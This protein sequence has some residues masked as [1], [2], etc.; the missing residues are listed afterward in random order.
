M[1]TR[2]GRTLEP[3]RGAATA[4]AR[5]Y[6][7]EGALAYAPVVMWLRSQSLR[8]RVS[9]MDRSRLYELA[10]LLPELLDQ[11]PRP[12]P[13]LPLPASEQRQR[14]FDAV[15]AAVL[16]SGRPLLLVGDDVHWWDRE[17]LELLHY[18]LR[19]RPEA[20]LL[21]VATCRREEVDDTHPLNE[22]VT[23]MQL[24]ER[25][26]DIALERFTQ[27]ETAT[28]AERLTGMRLAEPAARE[29]FGE[30]EGN[31]LFVVEV[32]RAGWR[33]GQ[34]DPGRIS[35]K[36]QAV[37]SSRL[38]RL[39][40]PAR[41]LA[42]VAAT[43]GREFKIETLAAASE[44]GTGVLVQAL[45]ELWR[46]RIVREHGLDAYDFSHDKI[47]EVAYQGL[48]PAQRRHRHLQVARAL[49]QVHGHRLGRVSGQ[50]ATHYERA[51][52][53]AEAVRWYA[54]AAEADRELQANDEAIRRLRRAL[55]LVA[56]AP[57]STEDEAR[58][59]ELRTALLAPLAAV[60]GFASSALAETHERALEL[61][62]ATGVEPAPPLLRSVAM[63]RL[64]A[65]AFEEA[66]GFGERLRMLGDREADDVLAVEG[67]YVLGIAAFW[68]GEFEAARR[69]LEA[70]VRRYRDEHRRAHL[71]HYLLDPKV[72]CLS[73]LGNTWWFLGRPDEAA[74]T[75][76]AAL[77][78]ASEI[79]HPPSHATALI[80]ATLLAVDM[81]EPERVRAYAA[82]LDDGLAHQWRPTQIIAAALNG[83]VDVLDGRATAGIARIQRVT[84]DLGTVDHAPG[85]GG[86]IMRVL[87]EACALAGNAQVGLAAADRAL[88][89][90]GGVRVWEAET[91]RLRAEFAAALGAPGTGPERSGNAAS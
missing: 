70:A 81:G 23:G 43:I 71:V 80:F 11:A 46:R 91:R 64:S 83:F 12:L 33:G 68:Q 20:R 50:L 53:V 6:P 90:G 73:R 75:R 57:A 42:R 36:V 16:G 21:V 30:T 51:G 47:R 84:E 77:A 15:A 28:L 82:S 48:S 38:A 24:L 61:S 45:D 40:P 49:E 79:A 62:R 27:D 13:P 2:S 67:E 1:S 52:A 35:P 31:P 76:D 54:R 60:E 89:M 56:A 34:R 44:A 3:R 4:T 78:L 63:V 39:S 41:E 9:R 14:L 88:R 58:E 7:A 22:L 19:I 8:P 87:L 10:R 26:T 59:L 37:I 29:L 18:L 17:S 55:D 72:V 85:M 25:V 74:R 86:A 65:G 32:V 66:R 5:S 69:H